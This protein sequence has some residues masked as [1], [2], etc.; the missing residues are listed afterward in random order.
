MIVKR[1]EGSAPLGNIFRIGVR[2]FSHPEISELLRT[3]AEIEVRVQLLDDKGESSF[4][5]AILD[6]E[7]RSSHPDNL[8]IVTVP[9]EFSGD[10]V[11]RIRIDKMIKPGNFFHKNEPYIAKVDVTS[12]A[13]V[14]ILGLRIEGVLFAPID[15]D[16]ETPPWVE[17]MKVN[18]LEL[19]RLARVCGEVVLEG[20]SSVR[21]Q[22]GPKENAFLGDKLLFGGTSYTRQEL[23]AMGFEPD[24][25][26]KGFTYVTPD[27]RFFYFSA[28]KRLELEYQ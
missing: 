10:W 7:N 8:C 16:E 1:T 9:Q 18:G 22:F 11:M 13:Q 26:V 17:G 2:I 28:I 25:P 5:G 21:I 12:L 6:F 24:I 27:G 20:M 4:E 3:G 14:D 15:Q 19:L 23:G